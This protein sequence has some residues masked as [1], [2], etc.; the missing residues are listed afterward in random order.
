[1][2]YLGGAVKSYFAPAV[3]VAL[4]LVPIHDS[5]REGMLVRQLTKAMP[6]YKDHN[7]AVVT[8]SQDVANEAIIAFSPREMLQDFK[9]GG[10]PISAIATIMGVERK[11]I[12]AWLD[13]STIKLANEDKLS[14]LYGLL[15]EQKTASYRNLYRYMGREV[16]GNT[17][18]GLLSADN[19]DQKLAR[20][21][22]TKLWPM[23]ER[24]EKSLASNETKAG[25]KNPATEELT[26]AYIS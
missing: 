15:N 14:S 20:D 26:E 7:L 8:P 11:T 2:N 9:E 13:G 23:A 6:F 25:S 1:M 16:D 22:L 17:L 19:F 10:L 18:M 3:S 21:M 12:Y 4:S 5:Y 24:I